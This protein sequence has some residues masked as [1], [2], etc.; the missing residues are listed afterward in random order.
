MSTTPVIFDC[1][2][3]LQIMLNRRG[4]AYACWEKVLAGKADLF[5]TPTILTEIRRL[6]DHKK[7]RRFGNFTHERVERF[8]EELLDAATLAADPPPIFSYSRD[9]DDAHYVNLAISTNAQ[10]VV[11][12]DK[13]L[14]DLM[15][16]ANVDG[17]MLRG[18]H[19]AFRVVTP[20]E[21]LKSFEAA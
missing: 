8:I 15:D 1:N 3:Y 7:L 19:P 20:P 13:D 14:L 2:V 21:F 11:S 6:P 12:N 17:K 4:A 10:L 16:D 18:A 5:V 9:P